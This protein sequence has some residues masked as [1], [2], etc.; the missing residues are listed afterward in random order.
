[1]QRLQAHY[2]DVVRPQMIKDFGYANVMQAPKVQ[3]VLTEHAHYFTDETGRKPVATRE[4]DRW[5]LSPHIGV[6]LEYDDDKGFSWRV[7]GNE[8]IV[9]VLRKIRKALEAE[10][11][12][13]GT[14][15]YLKT[16]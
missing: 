4:N 8:H 7:H 9:P 13:K 5:E 10:T 3:K 12:I 1:M 14:V 2:G 15:T 6:S 16:V 11:G